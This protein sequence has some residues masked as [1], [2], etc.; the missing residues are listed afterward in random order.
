MLLLLVHDPSKQN[1]DRAGTLLSLKSKLRLQ[2]KKS[3]KKPK[4]RNPDFK[5][6]TRIYTQKLPI[7]LNFFIIPKAQN[8][9]TTVHVHITHIIF[10]I[11]DSCK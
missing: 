3:K 10:F 7:A 6:E 2:I 11:T 9:Y 5:R 4:R 8:S 1:C